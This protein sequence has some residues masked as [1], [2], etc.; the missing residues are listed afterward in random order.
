MIPALYEQRWVSITGALASGLAPSQNFLYAKTA[1]SDHDFFNRIASNLAL[2]LVAWAVVGAAMVWNTMRRADG[3]DQPAL[4]RAITALALAATLLML[5]MTS[6]VWRYLPELKFVQFPWRWMSVIAVC[7]TV[8]T[9]VSMKGRMQWVWLLVVTAAIAASGFYLG[10]NTWWDTEDMP[11][12][13]TALHDGVGFEGTDE[14]DPLGDDHSDLQQRQPRARFISPAG[15]PG[16]QRQIKVALWTPEHRRLR[17]NTP[18]ADRLAIRLVDYPAWVVTV[19]GNPAKVQHAAGTAQMIIPVPAG[20]S[21]VEIRFTRTWDRT[22][23][24]WISALTACGSIVL[25]VWRRRNAIAARK[26]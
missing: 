8:F 9:A 1:D 18:E 4:L 7:A 14:Y 17:A 20:T 11:S 3:Q 24:G 16:E 10:R 6:L 2:M 19:D 5:P 13:E 22:M 23:G 26:A 15:R 21:E 25:L 12:L